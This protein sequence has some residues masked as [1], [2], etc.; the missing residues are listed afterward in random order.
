MD[1]SD[2]FSDMQRDALE[3]LRQMQ[4]RSKSAI[5]IPQE[6]PRVAESELPITSS[7]SDPL[8][9][10]LSRLGING[11]RLLIIVMLILLYKNKADIKLLLALAYL[12]L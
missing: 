5:E 10:M 11:D 7:Q 8:S 4:E 12:L 6:P 2:N 9:N 1:Y 3:R